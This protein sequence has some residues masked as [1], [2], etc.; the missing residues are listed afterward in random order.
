MTTDIKI[1]EKLFNQLNDNENKFYPKDLVKQKSKKAKYYYKDIKDNCY[2]NPHNKL[3]KRARSIYSSAMMI[4]NLLGTYLILKEKSYEV[5]YEEELPA[6]SSGKGKYETHKAHLDATLR[7]K[8]EIIFVEAK[9][10]EWLNAPKK[11]KE[12]Y[13]NKD[14]YLSVTKDKDTFINFFNSIID[15]N[16]LT[17]NGYKSI[18]QKYDAIQMT[19][20]ILGIYNFIKSRKNNNITNISLIN[21]IWD[22]PKIPQY[23]KEIEEAKEFIPKA[24]LYFKPLFKSLGID[25][26]IE[27]YTFHELKNMIDFTND[28]KRLEYLKRYDINM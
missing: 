21:C 2:F 23:E 5:L 11:L 6:L 15:K 7:N 25:F 12:A 16:T 10:T 4:Y 13:L 9:M 17:K 27:H 19:I 28:P 24:N 18:Y 14:K 20:H 3:D 8:D 22:C 26:N 1:F